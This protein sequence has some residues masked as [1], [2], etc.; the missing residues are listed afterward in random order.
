M[1]HVYVNINPVTL[2]NNTPID[3]WSFS[4]CVF[5][6]VTLVVNLQVLLRSSYWTM[7]LV[8]TVVLSELVTIAYALIHSSVHA[9]YDGDLLRVFHILMASLNFWLLTII[10]IFVCL[11]PDCLVMIYNSYNPMRILRRNEERPRYSN[12][13]VNEEV[14]LETMVNVH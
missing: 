1:T 9:R 11:I 5:H 3:Q 2:H 7:P 14:P 13:E 12:N 10:V 6:I 4:S 8:V